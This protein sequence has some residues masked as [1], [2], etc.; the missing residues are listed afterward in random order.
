M[1]AS[2]HASYFKLC[3]PLLDG[4]VVDTGGSST[5][6]NYIDRVK[7]ILLVVVPLRCGDSFVVRSSDVEVPLV[8]GTALEQVEIHQSRPL[9]V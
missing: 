6:A 2:P 3:S 8:V 4:S 5:T 1:E 7:G 9:R